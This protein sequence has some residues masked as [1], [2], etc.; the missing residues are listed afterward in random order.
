MILRGLEQSAS[1]P[2]RVWRCAFLAQHWPAEPVHPACVCLPTPLYGDR[3]AL[4]DPCND[5]SGSSSVRCRRGKRANHG[6]GHQHQR[7]DLDFG[8]DESAGRCRRRREWQ[9]VVPGA[10]HRA[11]IERPQLSPGERLDERTGD[12]VTGLSV[13][14]AV[15]TRPFALHVTFAQPAYLHGIFR[16]RWST[17]R[18]R[19]KTECRHNGDPSAHLPS[20]RFAGR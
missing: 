10:Q 2:N 15:K 18:P 7:Y 3:H 13:K 17:C 19:L 6:A 16:S 11:N 1:E 20:G 4:H 9:R 8:K 5:D 14:G 12:T